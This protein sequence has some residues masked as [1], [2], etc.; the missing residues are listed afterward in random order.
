MEV[1]FAKIKTKNIKS[2]K[3]SSQP[4]LVL[5]VHRFATANINPLERISNTEV[6]KKNPLLLTSFS[7][8]SNRCYIPS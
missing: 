4:I 6:W 1:T 3:K 2:V 7:G 8:Q 5:N